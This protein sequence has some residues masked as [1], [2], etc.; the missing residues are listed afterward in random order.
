M[1]N[2]KTVLGA[3]VVC[4]FLFASCEADQDVYTEDQQSIDVIGDN[5]KQAGGELDASSFEQEQGD[6]DDDN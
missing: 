1:K 5:D 4:L 2:L 3:L 6:E